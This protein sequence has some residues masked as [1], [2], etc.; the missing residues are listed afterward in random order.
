MAVTDRVRHA[1]R[2]AEIARLLLTHAHPDEE[3]DHAPALAADLERMGPAFIK[4][5]QL[6]STRTD[7][8][9]AAYCDAL[10]RLQ[11]DVEPLPPD[12][13]ASVVEEELGLPPTDVF[14]HW[15][16]TPIASASLG[17]VH[18]ARLH[19]GRRVVVKVQRPAAAAI[20]A[21]DMAALRE[22]AVVFD[23]HTDVGRRVGF[24][25]LIAQ[26]AESL[27]AELDY[28]REAGHLDRL[29][30]I[31]ADYDR[32]VV[33]QPVREVCTTRVLTMDDVGGRKVTTLTPIG[34]TEVDGD[35]LMEQLFRG[36]LDQVLVHGFFHA[37]P[38]P[39]NI[40]LLDDG[41]LALVDLGMVAAIG[42]RMQDQ[43][44]QLVLS[45]SEGRGE[46]AGRIAIEM[47]RRLD[48]FD[49][50]AFLL[51]A[52]SLVARSSA[53]LQDLEVGTLVA[54]LCRAA[55]ET[56]LRL[57]AELSMLAKALL[58][59]DRIAQLLAPDF[60]PSACVREHAAEVLQHRLRPER[61]RLAAT[62]LESRQFVEELPGRMNR[63]LE[64]V[65]D[66]ELRVHVDAIDQ[67][68]LLRGLRQLANRVT[69]GLVLAALIVGAAMLARADSTIATVC[70]VLAAICG[71][72][73]L[74]AITLEGW[75]QR[76]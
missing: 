16:A 31:L 8:L 9:P 62:A 24:S 44:V 37:D 20:V 7:L 13:V 14:E 28:R 26:F 23:D 58:N 18:R 10:S 2:Y 19:N 11:D 63:L 1:K 17:Q 68:E 33:P 70:F 25:E 73:L 3:A 56:G 60:D 72:G 57:P 64:S 6:L 30:A 47:G 4:L 59:L 41:R 29:G 22:L 15:D 46:E 50:A 34:R 12:V 36:Y 52:Q 69:M 66:G 48:D 53:G 75:R 39:G 49:E 43:L 76:R 35:A 45:V 51:A 74:G 40:L 65:A 27:D 21:D 32:L 67:V 61:H 38:H 42:P 5:G 71:F 55:V 54:D